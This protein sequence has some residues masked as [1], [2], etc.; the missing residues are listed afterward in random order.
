[1]F[2]LVFLFVSKTYFIGSHDDVI[3]WK[4]FSRY[5]P[6]VRGIHR[7]PVNS[8]HKGQWRGTLM[9][10]LICDW[11]DGWVNNREAGILRHHR[12]R[13]DVIVMF[14]KIWLGA[15]EGAVL[16][17]LSMYSYSLVAVD[18]KIFIAASATN[19]GNTLFLTKLVLCAMCF[20]KIP[21][22]W[23]FG[24]SATKDGNMCLHWKIGSWWRHQMETFSTLLAFCAGNSP[25]TGELS[26]QRPV[27]R[28]FDVLWSAPE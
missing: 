16:D 18:Q 6:F 15:I 8:H 23:H 2:L 26:A 12:A 4:H 17:C 7:S 14:E 25:V 28:C 24:T 5:W 9:F 21:S 1:M 3:K 19:R 11:I 20:P 22:L 10:S 13:Y 27:T